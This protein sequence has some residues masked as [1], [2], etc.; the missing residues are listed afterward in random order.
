MPD[1]QPTRLVIVWN[2][3]GVFQGASVEGVLQGTANP[4]Q[5]LALTD[6]AS[7]PILTGILG[8]LP[9]VLAEVETL[10]SQLSSAA[11]AYA[12]L[13]AE[14]ANLKEQLDGLQTPEPVGDWAAF[15]M[16][17]AQSTAYLRIAG[18]NGSTAVLASQLIWAIGSQTF[19]EV[20]TLWNAIANYAS[21]TPEEIAELNDLAAET[22]VAFQ[23]NQ[24]GLMETPTNG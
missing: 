19:S 23:L 13:Q 18:F 21:P 10:R 8:D 15:R 4:T 24:Q 7:N 11:T 14:N 12:A 17:I 9:V 22:G 3:N 6:I 2:Q 20:P 1:F 16:A 5:P